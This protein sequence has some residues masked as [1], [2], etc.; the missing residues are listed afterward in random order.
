MATAVAAYW[1]TA[2]ELAKQLDS[3]NFALPEWQPQLIPLIAW[4]LVIKLHRI[5]GRVDR[6]S[7]LASQSPTHLAHSLQLCQ[8]YLTYSHDY[9]AE[10]VGESN[11][12][13]APQL[14]TSIGLNFE[15][16]SSRDRVRYFS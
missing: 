4:P 13:L 11:T 9:I 3:S 6:L 1:S 14:T 7:Q 15:N 12:Q 2:T 16:A 5:L 10:C 8:E